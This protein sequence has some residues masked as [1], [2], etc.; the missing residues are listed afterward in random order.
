MNDD[1]IE[2]ELTSHPVAP[3]V[4]PDITGRGRVDCPCGGVSIT[5]TSVNCPAGTNIQLACPHCGLLLEARCIDE[6]DAA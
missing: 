3:F 6:E 2:V 1:E 4:V 5:N